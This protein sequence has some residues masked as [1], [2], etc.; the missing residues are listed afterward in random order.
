[1]N[2]AAGG[3]RTPDQRLR[4]FVSSTLKELAPERRAARAAIERLALAP[5]MF[6]LGARPYPPRSL[7]RAYLEQSDI[8]VGVYWEEYGWIAPGEQVSGLEDE[9]ALAPD[10]PK[11]IYIKAGT[12]RQPRLEDL[13]ARIRDDDA[14][15]YVSFTQADE[16]AELLTADLA[17]LL[18]ERFDAAGPRGADLPDAAAPVT[19]TEV[20]GVPSPLTRLLGREEELDAVT[21]MLLEKEHRLVT[22]T[23][24]GGIGKSRLAVA[25]ARAVEAAFPD[26]VAFVDLAPVDDPDQVIPAIAHALGIRD[27]GEPPLAEKVAIALGDRRMLLVLDNVEQV[28]D[29]APALSALLG[30]TSVSVLATSRILLRIGGEQSVDLGPLPAAVAAD[31]F[32]E[33]AR[34]VKP[35]FAVT[36][37]NA[38]SVDAIC[39]ALDGAPLALE[40]AAAR[41][42]VLTPEAM[43]DRLDHALTLL[44]GGARDLPERQ[45]TMQATIEWS[46][47]LLGDDQ[48]ELLLRL[49]VFR[50]GFGLEAA[51][52]MSA[53]LDG[54]DAVEALGEL[55]DGSLVREQDRGS[56]AWFAMP[57]IVR[58]Y[59]RARLEA[60]GTLDDCADRHAQFFV[61]LAAEAGRELINPRQAVWMSRLV[62][63]REE[64]RAAIAHLIDERRWDDVIECVWPLYWFWWVGGQH[65]EVRVW[66]AR[67]LEHEDELSERARTIALYYEN[68]IAS[69]QSPDPSIV[70]V[71][72]QCADYFERE[73]DGFGEALVL[74]SLALA[75]LTMASPDLDGAE[76]ALRRALRLVE[77]LDDAFGRAIIGNL[78]GRTALMRGRTDEAIELFDAGLAIAHRIDDKLGQTI[79]LNYLGW[80]RVMLAD[81]DGA[82]TC[83][84]EQLLISSSVGHEDGI[85][86]ALEGLFALAAL[87]GDV[88]LAGRLL[89]AAEDVRERKGL[90]AGSAFSFHQ[91]ILDGVLAGP[92]ADRFAVARREGRDA[93]LAEVVELA[94]A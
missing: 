81:L 34:A 4:V 16:L 22:I 45:R 50:G 24:P 27:T 23:G 86:Y 39:A 14:A 46:T 47:R 43:V 8:F 2:A 32:V 30:A 57:A 68:S 79:A 42:R 36:D 38:A 63:E 31:L 26:G 11:L 84:T 62:D 37:E 29:A 64:L 51:E 87:A 66:M 76:A 93:E 69:M 65:G 20:I 9:W 82:R 85:A 25:A 74:G 91:P 73:H 5:V 60:D 94:L 33:R 54:T 92:E 10:I 7:Y 53:G 49:G 44:A 15:S 3:I 67:L 55:V 28:V 90:F 61:R 59:A 56:R 80:A 13:L 77:D 35:D 52:W 41:A 48:R 89:G 75:Q 17:T 40:L 18:A 72:E 58:E 71:L 1:M 70:P 83:F 78:L 21:R 12:D 19:S 88:E 6:E